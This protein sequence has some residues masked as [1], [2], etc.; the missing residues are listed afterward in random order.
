MGVRRS[1]AGLLLAAALL[2]ASQA[3]AQTSRPPQVAVVGL[4]EKLQGPYYARFIEGMR[5]LG[6]EDGRNVVYVYRWAE[7]RFDRLPAIAREVVALRPDVIFTAS[8]PAVRAMQEATSTIPTVAF[9]PN[10]V[11]Q[12]FASSLARPAG[13]LTGIGFQ[14]TEL[15][16]KRMEILQAIVPRAAKVAVIWNQQGAGPGSVQAIEAAARNRGVETRVFEVREPGEIASAVSSAKSWGAGG[17]VQLASPVLTMHRGALVDA[18]SR[19]AVPMICE[20]REYVVDG[21]LASYNVSILVA[22]R[23]LAGFVHRI[24]KGAAPSELPIEQPREFEFVVNQRTAQALGLTIPAAL[25]LRAS[26]VLR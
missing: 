4:D 11:A 2:S 5:S 7:G 20:T 8:P 14:D 10:Y 3:A 15:S 16:T 9:M 22:F 24:L 18:A 26:E 6:Y 21:C 17:I 1:A 23:E 19:S 25:L 13:N 12:G